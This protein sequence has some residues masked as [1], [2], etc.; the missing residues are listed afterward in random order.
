[1]IIS[2]L[3]FLIIVRLAWKSMSR[4]FANTKAVDAEFSV[5]DYV[6]PMDIVG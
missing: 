5:R 1:M 6:I 4:G 2:A 3:L